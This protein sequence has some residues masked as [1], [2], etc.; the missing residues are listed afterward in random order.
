MRAKVVTK[1]YLY[2][3]ARK[4][5]TFWFSPSAMQYDVTSC[6]SDFQNRGR[7][8]LLLEKALRPLLFVISS[9]ALK[10]L[11]C[12]RNLYS[13]LYSFLVGYKI[14]SALACSK[15]SDSGQW[16]KRKVDRREKN[17]EERRR[18]RG[19]FLPP[20][21]LPPTLFFCLLFFPSSPL[22]GRLEQAFLALTVSAERTTPTL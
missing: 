13:S 15:C 18:E 11:N 19:G 22:S 21:S 4:K 2:V 16:Y 20:L 9:N 7:T 3:L 14:F 8:P 17:A 5:G 1:I 12:F 10:V 6:F